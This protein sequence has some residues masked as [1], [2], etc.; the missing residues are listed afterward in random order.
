LKIE[1]RDETQPCETCGAGAPIFVPSANQ[2]L[3]AEFAQHLASL[4]A[5][6]RWFQFAK[7]RLVKKF[8]LLHDDIAAGLRQATVRL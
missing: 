2:H 4:R 1:I 3:E 7:K 5:D 8:G 6:L